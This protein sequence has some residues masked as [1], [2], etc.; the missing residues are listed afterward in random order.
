MADIE[1]VTIPTIPK[2]YLV[3]P[4]IN[5]R[6]AFHTAYCSDPGPIVAGQE[7]PLHRLEFWFGVA[8]NVPLTVYER[9]RDAGIATTNMPRVP[10]RE[11]ED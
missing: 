9:F 4:A 1:T 10:G 3:D 6:S 7:K 8:R 2:V 11:D 5:R